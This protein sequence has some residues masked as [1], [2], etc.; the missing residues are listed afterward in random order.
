MNIEEELDGISTSGGIEIK[1]GLVLNHNN[2]VR[3][4]A[5]SPNGKYI[6]SGCNDKIIRIWESKTGNLIREL[7]GHE[8]WV[9][10][11][12]I[13]PDGKYIISGSADKTIKIWDFKTGMLINTL[14][15]HNLHIFSIAL[16]HDGKTI[17]SSSWDKTIKIWD[18]KKGKLIT[19]L[20]GHK[21]CVYSISVSP[22]DKFLISG[23]W[24]RMINFW[25]LEE[26]ELGRSNE[27]HSSAIYSITISPDGKYIISGSEDNLIKIWDLGTGALLTK[28]EGHGGRIYTI[29]ISA[30]GK[31]LISGSEDNT[32][33]IWELITGR[34]L[35]T[36]KD[37]IDSI[38]TL[39]FFPDNKFI[40][41]GS[42]DKTIRI[43]NIEKWLKPPKAQKIKV[44]QKKK[45]K[46]HKDEKYYEKLPI[47]KEI[48]TLL[49]NFEERRRRFSLPEGEI[50]K[51]SEELS[52]LYD[53]ILKIDP[54]DKEI[55]FRQGYT[56]ATLKRYT[57]ALSC[58]KQAVKIDYNYT[59]A[60][61]ELGNVYSLLKNEKEAIEC[62][63]YVVKK[64]PND[65]KTWYNLG[66]AYYHIKNLEKAAECF[67]KNIQFDP[68][69]VDA[70]KALNKIMN[71]K[72]YKE[73]R[74]KIE[75]SEDTN[76]GHMIVDWDKDDYPY[77]KVMGY[78]TPWISSKLRTEINC[79]CGNSYNVD[80]IS[81]INTWA[82][83]NLHNEL[84]KKLIDGTN[85]TFK[86]PK[87]HNLNKISKKVLIIYPEGKFWVP[88]NENPNKIKKILT[89]FGVLEENGS[90]VD[91]FVKMFL[92]REASHIRD[93][94]YMPLYDIFGIKTKQDREDFIKFLYENIKT[95]QDLVEFHEALLFNT[96]FHKGDVPS[97]IKK[98]KN[99]I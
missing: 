90:I 25:L 52:R 80:Y 89:N 10:T 14:K 9:L 71:E 58:F 37:H 7:K 77:S 73:E 88:T 33:K 18:L 4:I 49:L 2:T 95:F 39:A 69:D 22:N 82:G 50:E 27:A 15:G 83:R 67:K 42:A 54:N 84:I 6:I 62:Y 74:E 20:E 98:W 24:D 64:N 40:A 75:A 3:S 48:L 45:K 59:E 63:E 5:I 93:T 96:K 70:R 13:S 30:D 38:F 26:G 92:K 53:K 32:I 85:Y 68:Y 47:N 8:N 79:I 41:S 94:A 17:I 11:V 81:D 97:L 72:T 65:D 56:H 28:L 61:R 34:I 36:I 29:D 43:W 87:C 91:G 44:E 86:C 76:Y 16:T 57:K 35:H 31:F 1:E 23:S 19:T 66:V 46:I 78:P 12:L 51:V 60:W 99:R 55:W 21:D